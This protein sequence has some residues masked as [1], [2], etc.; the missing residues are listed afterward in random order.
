MFTFGDVLPGLFLS[1]L[2][3][4]NLLVIYDGGSVGACMVDSENNF[5]FV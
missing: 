2:F 4:I 3:F 5:F 1:I